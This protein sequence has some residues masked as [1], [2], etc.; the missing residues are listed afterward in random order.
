LV[1]KG[2]AVEMMFVS[3]ALTISASAVTLESGS[4][5]DLV[6]VRNIDSGKILSGT[7]M[8]DGSIR[9]GAT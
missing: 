1:E 9:V 4:A 6:K 7:V 2:A 5:G 3:G 8:A